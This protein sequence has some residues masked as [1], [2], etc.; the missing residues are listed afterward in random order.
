MH[1]LF[2][3]QLALC[4]YLDMIFERSSIFAMENIIGLGFERGDS[5][6]QCRRFLVAAHEIARLQ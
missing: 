2:L 5:G 6:I 4:R 3:F 1:S